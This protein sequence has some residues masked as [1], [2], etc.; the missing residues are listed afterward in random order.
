MTG[1]RPTDLSRRASR[2]ITCQHGHSFTADVWDVVDLRARPELGTLDEL[3]SVACAECGAR[4][5]PGTPLLAVEI[6]PDVAVLSVDGWARADRHGRELVAE[7]VGAP[8]PP[9]PDLVVVSTRSMLPVLLAATDSDDVRARLFERGSQGRLEPGSRDL[10]DALDGASVAHATYFAMTSLTTMST[11]AEL[12]E[13][14]T[15][16]QQAGA[17]AALR[18]VRD[19]FDELAAGDSDPRLGAEWC[20]FVERLA[21]GANPVHA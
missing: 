6:L 19:N 15:R 7:A 14:T 1:D 12:E 3:S 18:Y 5:E 4:T 11:P 21:S 10:V 2:R 13:A 17:A 9:P 8:V 20:R 16:L